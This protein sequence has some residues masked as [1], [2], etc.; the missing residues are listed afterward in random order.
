ML[1]P[2]VPM[3]Q[4]SRSNKREADRTLATFWSKNSLVKCVLVILCLEVISNFSWLWTFL[5]YHYVFD[6]TGLWNEASTY[7]RSHSKSLVCPFRFANDWLSVKSYS[8]NFTKDNFLE[9]K[10]KSN[11]HQT[12]TEILSVTTLRILRFFFIGFQAQIRHSLRPI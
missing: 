10:V 11:Q 1:L 12:A 2:E 7:W 5:L 3:F 6:I 9:D 8:L 4:A